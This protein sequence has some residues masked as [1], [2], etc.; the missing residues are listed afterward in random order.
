MEPASRGQCGGST[1]GLARVPN[2][3]STRTGQQ[4]PQGDGRC[5]R[6]RTPDT[7]TP[8][9]GVREALLLAR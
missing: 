1:Q 4:P 9:A 6:L 2:K 7:S 5:I 8:L 3:L